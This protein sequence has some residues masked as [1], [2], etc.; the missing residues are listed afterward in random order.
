M[1]IKFQ[2]ITCNF[3]YASA[4]WALTH[5]SNLKFILYKIKD[6]NVSDK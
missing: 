1:S 3:N 2:I 6:E 5:A 4:I